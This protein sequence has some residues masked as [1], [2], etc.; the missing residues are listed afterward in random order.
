MGPLVTKCTVDSF[1]SGDDEKRYCKEGVP[2]DDEQCVVFSIGSQNKWGFELDVANR[3]KCK[4]YTFDCTTKPVIPPEIQDRVTYFKLCIA[5]TKQ[6][7]GT[8]EFVPYEELVERAGGIRPHLL[9]I[10]IE[11]WEWS[12]LPNIIE[13]SRRIMATTGQDVFPMQITIEFHLVTSFLLSWMGR[14]KDAGEVFTFFNHLWFVGGYGVVSRRPN[15]PV[16]EKR[17]AG[18]RFCNEI[19]LALLWY[20]E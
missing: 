11:G 2:L 5:G 20:P 1:A 3:T 13:S 6:K 15:L 18:C 9:K 7:I 10:D 17:I 12:V 8:R 16:P 14:D 4:I 19:V